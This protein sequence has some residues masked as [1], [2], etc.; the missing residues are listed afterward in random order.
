MKVTID[1]L[2]KEYLDTHV[3]PPGVE[4]EGLHLTIPYEGL[5]EVIKDC[6]AF[7]NNKLQEAHEESVKPNNKQL[8]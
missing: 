2:I 1:T 3:L 6:M 4:E 8:H 5:A 7:T